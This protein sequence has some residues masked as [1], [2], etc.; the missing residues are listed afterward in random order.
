MS[1]QEP[2][3]SVPPGIACNRCGCIGWLPYGDEM[4]DE[5]NWVEYL[6]D[7]AYIYYSCACGRTTQK[8]R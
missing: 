2:P 6:R 7:D 8:P 1:E 5:H 4:A 3:V